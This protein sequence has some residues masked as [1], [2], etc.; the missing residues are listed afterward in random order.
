MWVDQEML[1]TSSTFISKGDLD[2]AF[3]KVGHLS[4]QGLLIPEENKKACNK[5]DEYSIQLHE[6]L[7]SF[8]GF[9]FPFNDF[10]IGIL[11]NLLVSPLQ[12]CPMSWTYVKVF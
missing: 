4:D 1:D 5:Y 3:T 7:F 12:V 2:Q 11:K 6:C 10:D 8:I 9:H